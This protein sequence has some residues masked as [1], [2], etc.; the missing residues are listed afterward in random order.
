MVTLNCLT[1]YSLLEAYFFKVLQVFT[2]PLL[3]NN[4]LRTHEKFLITDS[5]VE[6]Q[7]SLKWSYIYLCLA[8][9][10]YLL[11]FVRWVHWCQVWRISAEQLFNTVTRKSTMWISHRLQ[12]WSSAMQ[13]PTQEKKKNYVVGTNKFTDVI[14][15]YGP[16]VFHMSLWYY[17]VCI[18]NSY[19]YL[20]GLGYTNRHV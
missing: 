16:S 20:L 18:C 12:N 9:H 15:S 14:F 3:H 11:Y 1:F 19:E 2:K 4:C 8:S 10:H 13:S 5:K 7:K 6:L 17:C